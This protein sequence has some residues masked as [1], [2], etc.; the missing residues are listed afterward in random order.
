[1]ILLYFVN[2]H[3]QRPCCSIGHCRSD[4]QVREWDSGTA[5]EEIPERK[6]RGMEFLQPGEK[7]AW[8]DAVS[9]FQYLKVQLWW[10]GRCFLLKHAEGQ[11]KR[12]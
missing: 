9:V 5:C 6:I 7:K 3:I 8:G 12:Q 10:R 2:A 11:D 1:M 4:C